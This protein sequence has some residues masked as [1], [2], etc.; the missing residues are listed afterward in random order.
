MNWASVLEWDSGP[1]QEYATDCEQ[2]QRQLQTA[3]DDLAAELSSVTGTG[4]TVTAVKNALKQRIK[5]IEEEVNYLISAAEIASEG[6]QGIN[7]IRANIEDI[8]QLAASW[9]IHIDA[10]GVASFLE[11]A[12]DAI[13]K[14]A[15]KPIDTA[16]RLKNIADRVAEVIEQAAALVDELGGKI[17][18]LAIGTYDNRV[19]YSATGSNR[20]KLPPPTASEQQVASWWSSLSDKDKK[21]MI[22]HYPEQ[23]GNLDGVDFTSRNEAN[24]IVLPQKKAEAEDEYNKYVASLPEDPSD[25][26]LEEAERLH[27][28]VRAFNNIEE[29]LSKGKSIEEG[30]DGVPRYLLA[31]DTTGPNVLAAVSQNNPDTAD[32]I[33][34]IVP[35]MTTNV[36]DSII[37]YDQKAGVMRENV[38]KHTDGSVAIVE[39]LNYDAPQG[40]DVIST[41]KAH[42]GA[43]RLAG[44][45]NGM[46][47]SRE[48]GAGDAHIT[49]ASHSYGSTTAGIAATQVGDGVIDD[50]IQFGSPG[51]GVQD[52]GELHVP[53][54]HAWVSAAHYPNDMVQ[55]IGPD[56]TFG[57]NPDTMD[58]YKHLSGDVGR[59]D[60]RK[61]PQIGVKAGLPPI[62]PAPFGLHSAYF[63]ENTKALDDISQVIAGK[64]Q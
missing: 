56:I 2:K 22:E 5:D 48:H 30:G 36:A 62:Y 10:S 7:E 39:F 6:V 44:F 34:V 40:A 26:Q 42:K 38:M 18:S 17:A 45:L 19:N 31:L 37:D 29:T 15:G 14:I 59:V 13:K 49:V 50:L 3:G 47:A 35:G 63:E 60:Y 33:G 61:T 24:R 21:W 11:S 12:W 46:D 23:I 32:H 4:R 28:R 58:G 52:V 27:N 57:K 54:G 8:Q 25:E 9:D 64:K 55:G 1:L 51:S 41:D 43:D 20:P 16:F 53:E